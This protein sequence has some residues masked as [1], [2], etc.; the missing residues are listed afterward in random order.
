[1]GANLW[2]WCCTVQGDKSEPQKSGVDIMRQHIRVRSSQIKL[3]TDQNERYMRA[4]LIY[5]FMPLK[6]SM[7]INPL[8]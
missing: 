5:L 2:L 7:R 8:V 6:G 3:G 4:Q 1:M